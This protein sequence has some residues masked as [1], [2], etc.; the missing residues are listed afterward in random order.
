[1][2]CDG[3][4]GG[5]ILAVTDKDIEMCSPAFKSLTEATKNIFSTE[6]ISIPYFAGTG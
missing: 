6:V 3:V 2:S 1:M 4:R 5:Y